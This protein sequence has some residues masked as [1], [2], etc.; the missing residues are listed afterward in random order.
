MSTSMPATAKAAA[1]PTSIEL[2]CADPEQPCKLPNALAGDPPLDQV[3]TRTWRRA[4]AARAAPSTGTR[5][6][7]H[8][9]NKDD[10]L[11]VASTQTGFRLLQEFRQHPSAGDRARPQRRQG[12]P[13]RRRRLHL[14]GCDVPEPG[15]G[16]R[17]G[18]QHE[19]RGGRRQGAGRHDRDRAGRSHPA[20]SA[21]H[22]Q[23]VRRRPGHAE[24]VARR[25]SDR[26][27]RRVRAR[28][29]EQRPASRTA[30]T[31]SAPA[32]RRPMAS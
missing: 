2:G 5:A 11:F 31:T 14:A 18:Q 7:S 19:R 20:D 10:I 23:G 4:C 1:R 24:A 8:A 32:R 6:S 12:A 17:H 16:R 21:T 30:P 22:V 15:D 9:D 3:V 13:D 27:V 29:R 26:G 28:Q 25:R